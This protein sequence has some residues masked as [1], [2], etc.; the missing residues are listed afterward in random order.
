LALSPSTAVPGL[1]GLPRQAVGALGPLKIPL[2]HWVFPANPWGSPV[3]YPLHLPAR[4]VSRARECSGSGADGKIPLPAKSY[5]WHV[6]YR[7]NSSGSDLNLSPGTAVPDLFRLPTAG[8]KGLVD[9]PSNREILP[10]NCWTLG[11]LKTPSIC[12]R[13]GHGSALRGCTLRWFPTHIIRGLEQRP[14]N[15]PQV[16]IKGRK[17]GL[18]FS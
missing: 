3:E 1:P 15:R 14:G 8:V 7:V 5:E 18:N 17:S 16:R 2:N 4:L 12:W 9:T 13:V 11:P 6:V 10:A